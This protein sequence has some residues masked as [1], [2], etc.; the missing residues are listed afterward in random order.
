MKA[1]GRDVSFC[2]LLNSLRLLPAFTLLR[3]RPCPLSL[4]TTLSAKSL[5]FLRTTSRNVALR[6]VLLFSVFRR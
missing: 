4:F 5:T 1:L 2:I 3:L 6:S